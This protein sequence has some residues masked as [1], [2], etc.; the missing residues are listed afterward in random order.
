MTVIHRKLCV[1]CAPKV[2]NL[3]QSTSLGNSKDSL[4]WDETG[5]SLKQV[6]DMMAFREHL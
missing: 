3:H 4:L 5:H 6:T 2:E 1:S